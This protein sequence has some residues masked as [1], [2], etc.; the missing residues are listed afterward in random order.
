LELWNFGKV[1]L[2]VGDKHCF[3]TQNNSGRSDIKS[4][5]AFGN[6][7]YDNQLLRRLNDNA[8]ALLANGN[9]IN[10]FEFKNL[11]N[12]NSLILTVFK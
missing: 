2:I 10:A 12:S 1:F 9:F 6:S 3:Y 5:L 7:A 8:I 4:A 11:G